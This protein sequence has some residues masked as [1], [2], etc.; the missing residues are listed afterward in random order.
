MLLT[1][2][3][4]YPIHRIMKRIKAYS[5]S[6]IRSTLNSYAQVFFSD[7]RVFAII[8]ILV[9]FFD[10]YAGISGLCSVIISN[11]AAYLIGF[12]RSHIRR[13]YYGFNS[14]LVGLGL[15]IFYQPTAEF[16]LLLFFT[17][18]LTLLLTVMLEGVIGKYYLPYL[19]VPFL[20]AIWMVLLASRQFAS[21]DIS[22]RGIYM[23]NEMYALGGLS[24]V[25]IYE[26]FTALP[27]PESIVIYFRSLG[28]IFF[29]Y[30]L[31]TGI[32]IAAG[33]LI[34]SRIAFLLSLAGF[35][36]AYLFYHVFGGD[37]GALGYT[38]IGF[39]FILTS[40]AVGG[41]FI[42][43][44]R[45]SYL[46]VVLLTP[47]TVIVIIS[48]NAIF[49]LFQLSVYSLPFNIV[50]LLFLYVLKF[51]ERHF[52][53]PQLVAIQHFSPEK[54]L[55][56]HLNYANRFASL[57][58]KLSLPFWGF[59]KVTQ[60]YDGEYT[61]Q[62][63]WRH[64]WDFEIED[65]EGQRY[66]H[67][68]KQPED[69]YAYG[70]PVVA[71]ADGWVELIQD[72][73]DDNPVGGINTRQNWGNT[74]IIRHADQLFTKISH[75]RKGSFKVK[76]GDQVKLGTVL[77]QCGNSGR[78]PV[79]HVHF[80]VQREPYIGAPTI[81]Y[82]FSHIVVKTNTHPS[83][84][85]SGIPE[86]NQNISNIEKNEL[87]EKA[88]HFVPGQIL[89]M[90]ISGANGS[91]KQETL[92]VE[93]DLQ[94]NVYILSEQTQAR[95]Y[96]R[97]E[98][99][100]FFFTHYQGSRNSVLYHFFLA[101]FKI[102]KGFY[103][104]MIVEDALPL[105]HFH[106]PVVLFIQDLAAPFFVFLRSAY[107]LTYRHFRNEFSGPEIILHAVCEAK[108]MNKSLKRITFDICI[109]ESGFSRLT[110]YEQDKKM[111]VKCI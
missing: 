5:S 71:P 22:E 70:K 102:V 83:L 50:V 29:Q 55:Y 1:D 39:N 61:H 94:N 51:R 44:S 108:F 101:H 26:W 14:L 98:G 27:L 10:L 87:L 47:L 60:G 30:H 11:S 36:L 76:T 8:L 42:I 64:A 35:Y 24:L 2:A 15:G 46:W 33:L 104:D 16:Y 53:K 59:W 93:V 54:N 4:L 107:R 75:L 89:T 77:A 38:Y 82:P 25:R 48:T 19:S 56:A 81:A 72:G 37:F 79:P 69:F 17:S 105:N 78:S 99:S 21:L 6:L 40:I 57:P 85:V 111:E 73:V 13:G 86:T 45:Y 100:V 12:N 80:Q 28:A 49:S 74:I 20:L 23:L 58:V 66:Q 106:H 110:I 96:F 63:K 68:G 103:R 7:H 88:F 52:K 91:R 90:E 9:T 65:D 18:L 67:H 109:S 3:V 32:L 41:Y 43:P 95:A 84:L 34:Y 62:N 97:N 92:R 31:F